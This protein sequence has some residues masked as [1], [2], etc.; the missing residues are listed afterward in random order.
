MAEQKR[1][2]VGRLGAFRKIRYILLLKLTLVTLSTLLTLSRLVTIITLIRRVQ[3]V[4]KEDDVSLGE[5]GSKEERVS[6]RQRSRGGKVR[7]SHLENWN[8]YYNFD[9]SNI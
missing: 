2:S 9:E 4:K 3:S 8:D 6:F 7:D 1:M 5:G